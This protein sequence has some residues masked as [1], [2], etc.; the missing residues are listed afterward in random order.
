MTSNDLAPDFDFSTMETLLDT[1]LR[2]ESATEFCRA[3]VHSDITDAPVQGCQIYLLDNSSAL[4]RV[5][6]YG[7]ALPWDESGLSAWDDSPISLAIR[8]KDYVFDTQLTDQMALLAIPLLRDGIPLGCLVLVLAPNV[9]QEPLHKNLMQIL[10]KL[11]TYCLV[12]M[13]LVDQGTSQ[14]EPNGENLT[15]R[16][17]TILDLMAQGLV[18]AEI[19]GQL[20]VSESTV[21]QETVRIYR[22][23]GVPN[24]SEAA[25]KGRALGLI[26]RPPPPRVEP[27]LS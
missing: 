3:I 20:M 22:A 16:Q 21:R 14:R 12:N 25:K 15:S 6:G 17:I 11:A 4:S 26:K 27:L 23:L 2:S 5:A 10:G 13:T 24:R 7:M 9:E 8:S 18:N 19:A 1:L